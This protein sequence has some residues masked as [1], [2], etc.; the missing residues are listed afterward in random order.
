MTYSRDPDD[1]HGDEIIA[2]IELCIRRNGAMSVGGHIN[3][4]AYAI[5]MCEQAKDA[6]RNYH[7]RRRLE[8][9]GKLIIPA[10]DVGLVA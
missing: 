8:H 2:K 3:D 10:R 6:I 9:N 4:E 5:A 7:S 1:L